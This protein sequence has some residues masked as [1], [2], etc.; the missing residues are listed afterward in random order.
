MSKCFPNLLDWFLLLQR[1]SLVRH[2]LSNIWFDFVRHLGGWLVSWLVGL[3]DTKEKPT[4]LG[5]AVLL[6]SFEQLGY[7]LM[8]NLDCTSLVTGQTGCDFLLSLTTQVPSYMDAFFVPSAHFSVMT[9]ILCLRFLIFKKFHLY[10][11]ST[12]SQKSRA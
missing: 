11:V 4:A 3:W 10:Y 12:H 5:M 8:M 9:L 2:I 6:L 1:R 7:Y